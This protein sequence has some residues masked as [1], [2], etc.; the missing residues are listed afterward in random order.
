[1]LCR[2]I[3]FTFSRPHDRRSVTARL[4]V[5]TKLCVK[6]FTS[7]FFFK[8]QAASVA[9]VD[10]IRLNTSGAREASSRIARSAGKAHQKLER[11]ST[12]ATLAKE[13]HK[14]CVK[15]EEEKR[16]EEQELK[17]TLAL[18]QTAGR[19]GRHAPHQ[20]A[21]RSGRHSPHQSSGRSDRRATNHRDRSNTAG[22]ISYYQ[23]APPNSQVHWINKKFF[24]ANNEPLGKRPVQSSVDAVTGAKASTSAQPTVEQQLPLQTLTLSEE[25]PSLTTVPHPT[26]SLPSASELFIPTNSTSILQQ[27]RPV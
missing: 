16:K 13:L 19:S 24:S 18:I 14:T 25:T 5:E 22:R 12:I 15:E 4:V 11:A 10:A 3:I 6:E 9:A 1:M 7:E 26:G 8:S 20:T 23:S 27:R 17:A 2:V 21:G